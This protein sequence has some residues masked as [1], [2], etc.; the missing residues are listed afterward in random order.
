MIV[1]GARYLLPGIISKLLILMMV[2]IPL[3]SNV[4]WYVD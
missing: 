4:V 3:N 1:R 2:V